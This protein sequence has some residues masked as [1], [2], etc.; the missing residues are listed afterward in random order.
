MNLFPGRLA[1][2]SG[3][4]CLAALVVGCDNAE[5][6]S[7]WRDREIAVD[8]KDGDWLGVTQ[9]SIGESD[10]TVGLLNDEHNLYL[11]LRT[12]DRALLPQVMRGGLT[13]WFDPYGQKKKTF[14]VHFPIGRRET[15]PPPWM[16]GEGRP[17]GKWMEPSKAPPEELPKL[18]E[19][20]LTR[21]ELIGPDKDERCTLAVA[22]ADSQ[23]V[24]VKADLSGGLL[25]YELQV[26]LR[27]SAQH[28]YAIALPASDA[29]Q[30][31]SIGFE[32]GKRERPKGGFEGSFPGG[33]MRGGGGMGPPEDML[34]G[35]SFW[36]NVKLASKK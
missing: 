30:K 12:H 6:M 24:T 16:P 33:G 10:V 25:I 2:I 26:P 1:F 35:F 9:Y 8:G 7:Q 27:Q 29:G 17:E 15:D 34:K 11:L 4:L 31:I 18:L 13:V 14:G 19:E 21:V 20:S 23:G 5:M 22:A 3:L 32:T 28:S 36:A